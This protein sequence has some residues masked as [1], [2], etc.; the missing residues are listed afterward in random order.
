MFLDG[1]AWTASDDRAKERALAL[2][3]CTSED[4]AIAFI[5][6]AAAESRALLKSNE[7][8]LRALA[9]ELRVKRTMDSAAIDQCIA[10]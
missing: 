8:I 4:S 1:P 7:F 6:A 10:R 3:I 9:D 5:A 2:L